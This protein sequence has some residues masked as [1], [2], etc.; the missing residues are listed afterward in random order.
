MAEEQHQIEVVSTVNIRITDF[1]GR[2]DIQIENPRWTV[3]EQGNYLNL[4]YFT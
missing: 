3:L 2:D 4:I 1:N